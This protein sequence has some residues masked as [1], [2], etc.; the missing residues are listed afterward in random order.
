V[1]LIRAEVLPVA[2][3]KVP[4]VAILML[5]SA[6]L[7]ALFLSKIKMLSRLRLRARKSRKVKILQ[8]SLM[9]P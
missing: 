6:T 5:K 4:P 1:A 8:V 2:L 7:P 9:R 3:I